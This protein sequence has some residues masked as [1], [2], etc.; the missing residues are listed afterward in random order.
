MSLPLSDTARTVLVDVKAQIAQGWCQ[1]KLW[2]SEGEVCL[3]GAFLKTHANMR[4]VVTDLLAGAGKRWKLD[5]GV[6]EAIYELQSRLGMSLDAW[7]DMPGRTQ[8]QVIDL[9]DSVLTDSRLTPSDGAD[10]LPCPRRRRRCTTSA[11][12]PMAAAT[13]NS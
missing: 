5:P 12:P 11:N 13:T 8:A 6:D 1:Y 10:A 2:N 4:Y 7:N 3:F 9:I